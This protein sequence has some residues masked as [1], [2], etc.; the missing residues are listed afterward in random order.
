M[1]DLRLNPRLVLQTTAMVIITIGLVWLLTSIGGGPSQVSSHQTTTTPPPPEANRL[2][3]PASVWN[4]PIAASGALDPSSPQLISALTAEVTREEHAGI[5]PWIATGKASTPVYIVGPSQSNVRVQLDNPTPRWR[6]ALQRAFE[7]VPVPA[8][9]QPAR[10]RDEQMTVWQPSTDKL[11]EFFHMRR[12]ADGWHAAWGGAIENVSQSPGYYTTSSWPGTLTVWGASATSLPLAAGLITLADLR[13]GGINH[14]LAM[15]LPAP[16]AGV[17]AWPAERSDGTG[18]PDT[19][20]E[21]ARLRLDPNLDLNSLHLPLVT[22]MIAEAAQRY[23]IIVRDQTLEGIQFYAEDPT[24]YGG[25]KLYYGPH[26]FFGG[27]TPQQLLARFPWDRL[28]VLKL[29]LS[30]A[31]PRPGA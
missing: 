3:S 21:G 8:G 30:A 23:G 15:A 25:R 4:S 11:W 10:G 13:A 24:Q 31:Q 17:Y 20:P 7:A 2:F 26:G 6:Q 28:Q 5:G 29:E 27:M 9:A 14:A 22:R 12:Q 19:I 16:R 18:G 1:S